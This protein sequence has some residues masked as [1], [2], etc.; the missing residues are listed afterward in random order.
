MNEYILIKHSGNINDILTLIRESFGV[1]AYRIIEEILYIELEDINEDREFILGFFDAL[2]IDFNIENVYLGCPYENDEEFNV[3]FRIFKNLSKVYKGYYVFT[4]NDFLKSSFNELC[5]YL[6][7]KLIKYEDVIK[8]MFNS[9]LVITQATLKTYYHRNTVINKIN[10]IK[11]LTNLD[12][13]NFHHAMIIYRIL[14]K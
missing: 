5:S 10:N 2:A 9:N 7:K 3:Y 12:L 6:Y 13:K 1:N 14:N 11:L 4:I 8:A